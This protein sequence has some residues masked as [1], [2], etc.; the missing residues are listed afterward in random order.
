[1]P[2][3]SKNAPV[4]RKMCLTVDPEKLPD[5]IERLNSL[6]K[7]AQNGDE[8]SLPDLRKMLVPEVV[9]ML[10]G[11]LAERAADTQLNAFAGSNLFTR[12]VITQKMS[13]LRSELAG[14]NPTTVERLL[15]ERA[16]CCWLHLYSLEN[17]NSEKTTMTITLADYYQRSID[18]AH[19]RYLSSLKA[20]AEVRKLNVSIQ[21]NVARKQVNVAG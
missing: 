12:E 19:K 14:P 10:G 11:N 5:S 7:R 18:R 3:T 17:K 21:L 9:D 15:A 13:V 2:E 16:V 8:D 1:M 20:L 4:P 6:M